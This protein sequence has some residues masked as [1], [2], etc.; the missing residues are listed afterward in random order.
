MEQKFSLKQFL[1]LL[2]LIA[3]LVVGF[4]LLRSKQDLSA[5]D[6][7]LS[8]A[9]VARFATLT[10]EEKAKL[11]QDILQELNSL[12]QKK[13][14]SANSINSTNNNSANESRISISESV[15]GTIRV[16]HLDEFEKQDN[17]R[18]SRTDFFV[19]D[20]NGKE[21]QV[22]F[23]GEQPN[24]VTGQ[25]VKVRGMKVGNKFVSSIDTQML[26]EVDTLV[27]T[28]NIETTSVS[29]D[30][31]V[32]HLAVVV[33]QYS[34]TIAPV[35]GPT[36][37]SIPL[38]IDLVRDRLFTGTSSVSKYYAENNYGKIVIEGIQNPTEGDIFGPY[39][40]PYP[41]TGECDYPTWTSSARQLA[42]ASGVDFSG[43]T[44]IMYIGSYVPNC[45]GGLGEV[46]GGWSWM[47]GFVSL[48]G[49]AHELGHNFGFQHARSVSQCKD[50]SGND[51]SVGFNC[52]ISDYGDRYNVM[53]SGGFLHMNAQYK[54]VL[55]VLPNENVQDITQSGT[56]TISSLETE[57]SGIQLLR[58]PFQTNNTPM[59]Y[60]IDA[61]RAYGYDT[62][63]SA[64]SA[65]SRENALVGVHI[66]TADKYGNRT[67]LLDMVPEQVPVGSGFMGY[68]ALDSALVVGD[69]FYDPYRDITITNMGKVGDTYTI[70]V[71]F[72]PNYVS[73]ISE[74]SPKV[75]FT[76]ISDM[77]SIAGINRITFKGWS[78]QSAAKIELYIQENKVASCN[79]TT[80]CQYRWSLGKVASGL[81]KLT[82]KA[83]YPNNQVVRNI[84][85]VKK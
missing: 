70:S 71:T 69:S 5:E 27:V 31:Q 76:G 35:T 60:V 44:N 20:K 36:L 77:Q 83:Y 63:I 56:Y 28:E 21:T 33:Y 84:I 9:V 34:D 47:N 82:V 11:P 73:Q 25:K 1:T 39:T 54:N 10:D 6:A 74:G 37:G 22:F 52:F 48:Y 16:I 57:A 4:L 81:Y 49:M 29:E 42:E 65:T 50:I 80:N 75:F 79:N 85:W 23:L 2:L 14:L 38:T 64:P 12:V 41:S 59:W 67:T 15:E 17:S 7:A 62:A 40:I 43:Y 78:E 55:G 3:F 46:N 68:T 66:R 13:N 24:I 8:S 61:R 30:V 58:I 18:H 45:P 53:G 51:A 19:K 72:G 32:K 26:E